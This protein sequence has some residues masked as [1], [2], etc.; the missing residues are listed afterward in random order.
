V[1][2]QRTDDEPEL[3]RCLDCGTVYEQPSDGRDVELCPNCGYV[4]W[5]AL[6]TEQPTRK[7]AY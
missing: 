4:G 1:E 6:S 5:I 7:G 2:S 3:V